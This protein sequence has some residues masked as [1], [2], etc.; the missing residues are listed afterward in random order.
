MK[1]DIIE[2]IVLIAI[3]IVLLW[4]FPA[5]SQIDVS[6]DASPELDVAGYKLYWGLESRVYNSFKETPITKIELPLS[7][8][9]REKTYF[10]AVTA[11][12]NYGNEST[13][14]E[15]VAFFVTTNV[16]NDFVDFTEFDRVE[17]FNIL[18]QRIGELEKIG[19]SS[20]PSG[21]YIFR[22]W[23]DEKIVAHHRI[24]KIQ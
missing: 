12:D 10:F 22:C 14:S 20:L 3:F 2:I 5:F 18:G 7:L 23:K 1:K 16:R 11:F 13:F 24:G 15:E 19:W 21:S 17:V 6:W 4:A 8:F 9:E